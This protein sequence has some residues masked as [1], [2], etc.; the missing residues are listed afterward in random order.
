MIATESTALLEGREASAEELGC[1]LQSAPPEY[2]QGA[3]DNPALSEEHILEILRNPGA[4]AHLLQQIGLDPRWTRSYAVKAGL[5]CHPSTPSAASLHM[6]PFLFWR[7]LARVSD[8]FRLPP[9]LRRAAE[10]L[11]KE[12]LQDLA[13]GERMALARIAGRALICV[14]RN[15]SQEMVISALLNNPRMTE[16]DLLLMCNTSR[17][18]KVLTRVGQSER[19]RARPPVRLALAR[20]RHTPLALAVSLLPDLSEEDLRDLSQHRELPQALR[21]AAVRL[22]EERR[23]GAAAERR[24]T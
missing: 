11:L 17:S 24:R 20:N 7:D 18:P 21:S 12:R 10:N 4:P 15:E 14:L 22:L 3:L 2:L 19:W 5:V 1:R 8:N 6:L 16:E 13:L 23:R 9:P